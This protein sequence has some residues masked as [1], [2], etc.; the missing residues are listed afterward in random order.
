MVAALLTLALALPAAVPHAPELQW[1]VH[2]SASGTYAVDY[3][4]ERDLVD[5]QAGGS[6]SWEMKAL[7][8]GFAVDTDL[9]GL[10][11]DRERDLDRCALR[12]RAVLPPAGE[13]SGRLGVRDARVGL[14][15]DARRRGFQ[16][17]HPFG[18]L[19]NGLPNG[20]GSWK[21]RRRA[22]NAAP[23]AAR[24]RRRPE[25]SPAGGRRLAVRELA[26]EAFFVMRKAAEIRVDRE[27][28]CERLHLPAPAATGLFSTRSR[29]TPPPTAYVA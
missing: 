9:C 6:W 8:S 16:V 17:D 21:P 4:A 3:G 19:L 27:T 22:S 18:G 28:A 15:F 29:S 13:R 10:P 12:R 24:T 5:G 2:V 11:H 14:Y 20:C 7:A 26:L 23:P 1:R 25:R